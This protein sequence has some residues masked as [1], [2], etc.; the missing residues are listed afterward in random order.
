M[1]SVYHCSRY[2]RIEYRE[3]RETWTAVF[4]FC[5]YNL[6]TMVEVLCLCFSVVMTLEDVSS[7]G[8]HGVPLART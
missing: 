2:L 4:Y 3:E 5:N 8:L 1:L 7:I 6:I